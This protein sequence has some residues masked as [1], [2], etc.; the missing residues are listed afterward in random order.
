MDSME[1]DLTPPNAIRALQATVKELNQSLRKR[2][3]DYTLLNEL[4]ASVTGMLSVLG[5]DLG[6]T[7]PTE[8]QKQLYRDWKDAVRS[9]DFAKADECRASLMKLGLV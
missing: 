3:L 2:D 6:I 4:Y 1:D 9:K 7:P 8:E 5:I